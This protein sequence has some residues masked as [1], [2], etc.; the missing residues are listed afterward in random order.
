M[1]T[2]LKAVHWEQPFW[3][4]IDGLF[5]LGEPLGLSAAFALAACGILWLTARV[6]CSAGERA[7]DYKACI[8]PK[9][10]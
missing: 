2:Q 3:L 6:F 4:P 9:A 10:L 8:M 1:Q 5:T 7:R